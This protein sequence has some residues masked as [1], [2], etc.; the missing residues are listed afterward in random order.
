M[1]WSTLVDVPHRAREARAGASDDSTVTGIVNIDGAWHGAVL[2]RCPARVGVARDRRRCSRATTIRRST[3]SATRSGELTNM[4]AGNVKALL[5]APSAISLPTVAFGSNYEISVVGHAHRRHRAVHERVVIHSWCRSCSARATSA[6]VDDDRANVAA[7]IDRPWP[8]SSSSMTR[9]P[10]GASS[11]ARWRPLGYRVVEAADGRAGARSLSDRAT[12]S[13]AAR[14]RHARDGRACHPARRC[15]PTPTS[16]SDPRALP[17]RPHRRRRCRR[18]FGTRC[19][20]L[21]RKPCEPAELIARVA[22]GAA[23]EGARSR[24][25]ATGARAE[26][27]EHHRRS[28]RARQPPAHRSDDCRVDGERTAPT[29]IVTAIMVDVDHFKAGQRHVRTCR[30]RRGA[31]HRR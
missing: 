25:R 11:A 15:E 12:R 4:V 19:P 26:R 22:H 13:G 14:H 24:A 1:I 31:A 7:T 29:R 2:V 20:G 18:R 30:R 17:H 9:P 27:A 16:A 3:T 10:S 21:L 6:E 8:P 23:G 28:H 5:P